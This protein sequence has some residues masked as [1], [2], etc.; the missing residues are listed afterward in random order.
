MTP[1][2]EEVSRVFE[3]MRNCTIR[4]AAARQ[5]LQQRQEGFQKA[6]EAVRPFIKPDKL[7]EYVE[8]FFKTSK[9]AIA[10]AQKEVDAANDE[11]RSLAIK[12][13]EYRM[14]LDMAKLEETI[15]SSPEELVAKAAA[16]GVKVE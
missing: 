2:K 12:A 10:D 3:D 4:L 16:T 7:Q 5:A 9:A 6:I 8:M 1:T 14:L 11:W 13:D 15:R